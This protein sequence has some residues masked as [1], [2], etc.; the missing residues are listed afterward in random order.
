MLKLVT[1]WILLILLFVIAKSTASGCS[2]VMM[3]KASQV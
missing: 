2:V 1:E 3:G